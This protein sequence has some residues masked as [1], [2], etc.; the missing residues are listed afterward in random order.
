MMGADPLL[1]S[2]N[3][4]AQGFEATPARFYILFAFCLLSFN[5][6]LFWSVSN[7]YT[8]RAGIIA[9][10]RLLLTQQPLTCC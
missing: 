7:A 4:A 6:C 1:G 10:T 2:V 5:Q 3:T 9:R 8:T